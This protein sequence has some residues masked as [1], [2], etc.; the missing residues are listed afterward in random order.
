M[1]HHPLYCHIGKIKSGK[2]WV[3][4]DVALEHPGLPSLVKDAVTISWSCTKLH[5]SCIV[6]VLY[7]HP[8][9]EKLFRGQTL[10]AAMQQYRGWCTDSGDS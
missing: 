2:P 7:V 8:L 6:N 5:V 3:G 9:L 1:V 4:V 10:L